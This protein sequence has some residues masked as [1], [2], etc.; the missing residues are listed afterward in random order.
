MTESIDAWESTFLSFSSQT[1]KTKARGPSTP[2]PLL[3][4]ADNVDETLHRFLEGA[5]MR[6]DPPRDSMLNSGEGQA[7]GN[8]TESDLLDAGL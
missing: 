5:T 4:I 6:A 8:R 7:G 3:L 2:C 1:P